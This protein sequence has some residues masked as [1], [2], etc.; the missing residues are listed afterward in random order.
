MKIFAHT[1]Y[2]GTT[3]YNNHA[4]D[5]FRKLSDH[6]DLK[7]RNFTVGKTWSG[8]GPEPHNDEPYITDLDKKLLYQQTL[9]DGNN[10]RDDY[11]MYISDEKHWE[12]DLNIVLLETGHH[13]FYD[14]YI[15]P[16]IAFN[17]WESTEQPY[18]FFE[19]LKDFD[20]IWVPSKWQ[21]DCT[22]KQGIDESLVKVVPE[23]VDINV[24]YPEDTAHK[25]SDYDD[26][27]F[28]FLLFGRWDYRKSTKEIIET[29]LSTFSEDEPVDLIISIDN[30]FGE[31]LDGFKTTEERLEYYN[32]VDDRIK[33][34]HFPSREDYINYLKTGHVFL[35]CARSEG[36]NLPLIEAMS[37]GTP[38]IYSECSAQMEFAEGKGL[39]VRIIGEKK[40]DVNE[41]ARFKMTSLPGNYYEPDFI[42]LSE[43]MRDAYKNYSNH[44]VK[45]LEDSKIIH[46]DFNW[47]RIGEIGYKTALSF[48]EKYKSSDYVKPSSENSIHVSYINGPKVE[49]KGDKKQNYYV[50]FIDRDREEVIHSSNIKN[51]MWTSCSRRYYTNWIIKVN[52]VIVD[53]FNPKG[54]TILIGLDS[55][56]LGDT[57]A[58]TPYVVDFKEKHDCN[59]IFST[60]HNNW[61]EGLEEYKDITF[62]PPGF[63]VDCYSSY[64]IGWFR[65]DNGGWSRY[66]MYPNQVNLV[67]LQQTA[68][69][70][71]GL[72]YI[73][74]NYG[75]N[76]KIGERPIKNKYIVFGPQATSGC[77]EWV[78]DNWVELSHLL[79]EKGY[80]V[81]T[82][83]QNPYH[84][85]GV[86]N[87]FSEPMDVVATYLHHAEFM[88]GLGSGLS[89][90][91]WS[92]NKF[93]YMING[94]SEENHEF[95]NNIKKINNNL[96]IR[97]WNDPVHV[98][99]AGDWDWCPV[100]KGTD[101]QHVC[102]R[103]I[104][105][106]QV[107][108][109]LEL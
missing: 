19:K 49:I 109:K 10:N 12:S 56:S 2:I 47:D 96:C 102:Q 38:C 20:E 64:S 29:F 11:L 37:C 16:K 59:V 34:K 28:K 81:V 21:R 62:V 52:G 104:T 68:T 80:D 63:S 91:N 82:L 100:Y 94:F 61:F 30:P 31:K 106:K 71:L 54:K 45:A 41:Y 5:F 44:K 75:V 86:K 27:R 9:F 23:G 24:F 67:P 6:C 3:G 97:C 46:R 90:L 87:V 55:K 66:D 107:F 79:K 33:I 17:V 8:F 1:S 53:E 13:Y 40:A 18:D 14:D 7:I 51:N 74:R 70:I 22:I 25:L 4:R 39:P 36:W 101:K 92:L 99:D 57:L 108:D 78:Y 15:G 89:W 35:S 50:E 98:F 73:E 76:F 85:S 58:W 105:A 84:I 43:V 42:H 77:K 65:D 95:T 32:M 48:Y 26:G 83:T 93:T 103:S 88:I 60:F 69:D 72:D